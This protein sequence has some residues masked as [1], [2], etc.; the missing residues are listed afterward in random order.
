[1]SGTRLANVVGIPSGDHECWC[2][3]VTRE[4]YVR[5]VGQEPDE[6]FDV[7]PFAKEGS[8][9]RY[10]LYPDHLMGGTYDLQGKVVTLEVKCTVRE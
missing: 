10:K 6:E 9:Y 5:I 8:V 7:G 2:L 3:L 1:M 4:D